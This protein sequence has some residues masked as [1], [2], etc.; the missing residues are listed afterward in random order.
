[1]ALIEN[2]Q[3]EDLNAIEVALSYQRLLSECELRQE[4]LG[5][6]V[7]KNRIDYNQLPKTFK[8]AARDSIGSSR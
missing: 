4:D 5:T 7:G 3:R 1:M 6:R 2:I 8:T